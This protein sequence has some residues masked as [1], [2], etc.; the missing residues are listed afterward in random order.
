MNKVN[1]KQMLIDLLV[2]LNKVTVLA[3]EQSGVKRSSDLSKSLKYIP[4][5]DGIQLEVA[6]YYSYVSDGRRRYVKK[7]PI[8]ALIKFIKQ[9]GISPR[10][11]QTI[12]GLA[13]AIQTSIY[14]EGIKGKNY[15][16]KVANVAGFVSQEEIAT[17]L[18]NGIADELVSMF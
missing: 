3:L 1:I 15:M 8:E 18:M 7:V 2:D 13:Y 11:G 6:Y 14:K 9:N 5:K 17:D 4:T 10:P 12:S 16:D